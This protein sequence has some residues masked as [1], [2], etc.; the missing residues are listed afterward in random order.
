LI[1]DRL[2]NGLLRFAKFLT[3]LFQNGNVTRYLLFVF[4]PLLGFVPWLFFS[5]DLKQG[6]N[7]ELA[8]SIT[9]TQFILLSVISICT[10]MAVTSQR[11]LTAIVS[12]GGIGYCIAAFY[13]LLGAPDL[14]LTQVLVET[15]S[16]ILLV[17]LLHEIPLLR[18]ERKLWP[19]QM[20]SALIALGVGI[21]FS[22]LTWQ[23]LSVDV[24]PSIAHFF[25]EK[26]YLEANGKNVVNVILVDFRG[27]DTM[28]E[29]SVLGIGAVT[30]A[31]LLFKNKT[32]QGEKS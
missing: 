18:S 7:Y 32:P 15:L 27:F 1:F 31:A 23:A 17:F 3:D 20:V 25:G 6:L 21:S 16:V 5:K 22:V 14:A 28:G 24:A 9:P 19:N 11:R 13:V 4:L 10:F 12:M 26:S 8:E 30:L 2:L 29:I